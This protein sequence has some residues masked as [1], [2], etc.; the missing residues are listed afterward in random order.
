MYIIKNTLAASLV[1][2]ISSWCIAAGNPVAVGD[3]VGRDLSVALVG[4]L[5]H[6][7]LLA[8]NNNVSEVNQATD[9]VDVVRF[10]TVE[11]FKT[12]KYWGAKAKSNF[13]FKAPYTSASN[14]IIGLSNQ[15]RPYVAYTLWSATAKPAVQECTRYDANGKCTAFSWKKGTFRCDSFVRWMYEQTGNGSLGGSLPRTTFNSSLLTITR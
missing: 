3:V 11:G 8:S 14:Q 1:L 7:G 4:F 5:G 6:V 2:S 9:Y 15:Q 12:D 10:K 13:G